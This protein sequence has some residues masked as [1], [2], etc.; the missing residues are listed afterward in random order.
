MFLH[1]CRTALLTMRVSMRIGHRNFHL[2][3]FRKF[4][5]AKVVERQDD[6]G[7]HRSDDQRPFPQ[8]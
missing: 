1:P 7:D 8:T 2:R 6:H 4:R 3:T 5:S